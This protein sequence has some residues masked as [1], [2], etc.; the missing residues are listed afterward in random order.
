MPPDKFEEMLDREKPAITSLLAPYQKPERFFTLIYEF[1]KDPSLRSCTPESKLKCVAD[2]ANCG[3]EIGG[4]DKHCG[5]IPYGPEAQL[6]IFYQGIIYRLVKAKIVKHMYAALV[7]ENDFIEVRQGTRPELNHRPKMFGD[8][9]KVVGAYAVAFLPNGMTDFEIMELDDLKAVEAAAVRLAERNPKHKGPS[10]AWRFFPGE[11]Q[12]KSAIRRLAK[13][14]QGDRS[15]SDDE[16]R[17]LSATLEHDNRSFDLNAVDEPEDLPTT[18]VKMPPSNEALVLRAIGGGGPAFAQPVSA[19]GEKISS[20][21]EQMV[22]RLAKE[23]KM[24]RMYDLPQLLDVVRPGLE[25]T[26]DILV[27][28]LPNVVKAIEEWGT[29]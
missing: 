2:A 1:F 21:D 29:R 22:M 7:H 3:L 8:R 19:N 14:L 13:R 20:A 5:V 24:S 23:K 12:K 17:R 28:E 27:S 16:A 15:L 26:Q 4:P 10:P 25:D 18:A 9:G 11:M 6:Q